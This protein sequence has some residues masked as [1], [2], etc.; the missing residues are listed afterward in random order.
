[1]ALTGQRL[2]ALVALLVFAVSPLSVCAQAVC[3]F[4]CSF[5]EDSVRDSGLNSGKGNQVRLHS[6]EQSAGM[7]CHNLANS[8]GTH[9]G[10]FRS[11]DGACHRDTCVSSEGAAAASVVAQG[12]W[13]TAPTGIVAAKLFGSTPL[14]T[15]LTVGHRP[16]NYRLA[17]PDFLAASGTL[18][19]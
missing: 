7:H 19:I 6:V 11:H 3:S 8:D 14:P 13:S 5:H 2:K 16:R 18:R 9:P 4:S 12:N 15:A 17:C 1:M 10:A